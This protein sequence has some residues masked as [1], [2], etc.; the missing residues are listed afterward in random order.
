MRIDDLIK[1]LNIIVRT[2]PEAEIDAQHDEIFAEKYLPS[3]LTEEE[4][5]QM[6]AMGWSESCGS[7][8]HFV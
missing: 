2:Q 4:R 6:E 5:A 7:W 1:G 3:L 8:H